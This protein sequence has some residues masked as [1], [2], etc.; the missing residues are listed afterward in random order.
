MSLRVAGVSKTDPRF[1]AVKVPSIRTGTTAAPLRMGRIKRV[2]LKSLISPVVVR[3]P[4]GKT[5]TE[6]PS[7]IRCEACLKL[8]K[9][10]L[11]L[12]RFMGIWPDF[13]KIQPTRGIVNISSLVIMRKLYGIQA[14]VRKM[15]RK[16]A[17]FGIKM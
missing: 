5:T 14:S 16:L 11:G 17:W 15:S 4:S 8:C 13:F 10:F 2:A 1:R 7:P 9:P 12:F 6:I 3:V